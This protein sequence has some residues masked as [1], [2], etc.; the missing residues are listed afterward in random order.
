MIRHRPHK[1][2]DKKLSEAIV[3]GKNDFSATDFVCMYASSIVNVWEVL[4][5]LDWEKMSRSLSKDC[6]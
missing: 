4:S 1:D 2:S 5:L 3:K 6:K